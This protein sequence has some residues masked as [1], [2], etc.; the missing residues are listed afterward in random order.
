MTDPKK[1]V[2]L[3]A[4]GSIGDSVLRVIRKHQDSLE[5]LGISGHSNFAKLIEIAKEFK[6]PHAHLVKEPGNIGSFP[7]TTRFSFGNKALLELASM[8]ES[9]ICVVA[10][11]GAAGL[12]PTL[13][14]IESGQDIVLANKESLVMGGELVMKTAK[15]RDVRIIPA[16]SE[17]N[18]VFQCIQGEC[19]RQLES[20]ILTASGG[21]LR[22]TPIEKLPEVTLEETLLHPNWS[23]GPKV[24]IDSATM[25][26]KGLELI[27]AHW[28]F[29]L[30][31]EKLEVVIHPSSITHAIVRFIDGCCLAQLSPPSMTFALQNAI[32]FPNRLE[33]VEQSLDFSKPIDLSFYPPSPKRF[34]CLQ[35][36][37]ESLQAGGS[38]PLA[39]N[40]SN[41]IA[42]EAFRANRIGFMEIPSIIKDTLNMHDS[43]QAHSLEELLN[44]DSDIRRLAHER[45]L[46]H[47]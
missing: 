23:M 15:E 4:T 41:E 21:A 47:S 42:V 39:F 43:S 28:L 5:L 16:D 44:L 12:Q 20:I 19:N 40:A 17:H 24:T 1:I 31:P 13:S 14:A 9:D 11:V 46:A 26:N 7:E 33:G 36:A 35:L 25:A 38:A 10:I 32:L 34:P 3:G 18:A 8:E 45:V 30:P 29:G 2:L 6:V 37:R 22:D 27:E